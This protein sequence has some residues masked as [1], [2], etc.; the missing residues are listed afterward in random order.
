MVQFE[1]VDKKLFKNLD[2]KMNLIPIFGLSRTFTSCKIMS[3]RYG[4]VEENYNNI[5]EIF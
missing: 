2:F 5:S 3:H 4:K 1:R